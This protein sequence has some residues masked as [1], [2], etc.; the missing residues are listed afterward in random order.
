[1]RTQLHLPLLLAALA[2]PLHMAQAN[3]KVGPAAKAT[4]APPAPAAGEPASMT[5]P[6]MVPP[7][8]GGEAKA[9]SEE[10]D[11]ANE[12]MVDY[13]W[14]KSDVAFHA[15]DYPRAINL[16]KAIV[17]LAPDEVDSYG[18][19][20]W[21]MWSLGNSKEALDFIDQGLKANP[22]DPEMW[23]TAAEQY[24]LMKKFKDAQGAYGKAI[25]LSG[26]SAPELLRRCYAHAAEHAG[27]LSASLDTW[28]ALVKDYPNDAVD[29]NNLARVQ[30]LI[31]SG[32][33]G[34]ANTNAA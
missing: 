21:L 15:G 30:A 6:G 26:K 27:D 2:I 31:K 4:S 5:A 18:A 24:D 22:S 14:R 7:G 3:P 28:T 32:P 9:K 17:I 25:A 34:Q 13:F 8:R 11:L 10:S 12:S 20:A 33:G 29:K 16:H 1:M 23:N 19:G